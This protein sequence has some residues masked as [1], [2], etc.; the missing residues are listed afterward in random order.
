MVQGVGFRWFAQK[1]AQHY[2]V[3]GYVRNLPD[4]RVEVFAQGEKE[5]LDS[6]CE[7]LREGPSF[8]RTDD[9]SVRKVITDPD[10]SGFEI[11]F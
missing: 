3:A 9:F 2:G 5:I 11:R 8:S 6:F 4:G 10:V 7:A 1:Q